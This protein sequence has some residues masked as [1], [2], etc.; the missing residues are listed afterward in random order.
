MA[1][2]GASRKKAECQLK[3]ATP[4]I[5]EGQE[6]SWPD[7][8]R[9]LPSARLVKAR[10]RS[11][12]SHA[13]SD[14]QRSSAS[15]VRSAL[16][17]PRGSIRFRSVAVRRHPGAPCRRRRDGRG[18]IATSSGLP[19]LSSRRPSTWRRTRQFNRPC[20]IRPVPTP[21]GDPRDDAWLGAIGEHSTC[22]RPERPA[23]RR[24]VRG[25]LARIPGASLSRGPAT[26]RVASPSRPA[27]SASIAP[28]AAGS[29]RSTTANGRPI[30]AATAMVS[31]VP[32]ERAPARVR[33]RVASLSRTFQ[34]VR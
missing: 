29:S 8:N 27:T 19:L 7:P 2:H 31:S 34:R 10:R 21:T 13:S 24:A 25:P 14:N 23:S 11:P 33:I 5:P 18:R 12:M 9:T 30:S 32:G 6:I 22:G 4:G 20:S 15:A 26:L 28:A 16:S 17:G 3:G 1:A